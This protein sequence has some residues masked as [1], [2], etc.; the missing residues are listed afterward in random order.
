MKAIVAVSIVL[1]GYLL[2][3]SQVQAA[4]TCSKECRTFHR[5]CVKNHSQAACKTDLDICTKHCGKK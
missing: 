4:D 2:T 3:L 5:A 1:L